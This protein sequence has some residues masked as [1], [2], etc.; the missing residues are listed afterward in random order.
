[1]NDLDLI[2]ALRAD[3]AGPDPDQLARA[4]H[5]LLARTAATPRERRRRGRGRRLRWV[6]LTAALAV[7]LVIAVLEVPHAAS[8]PRKAL[9]SPAHLNNA[10][11]WLRAAAIHADADSASRPSPEQWIYSEAVEQQVGSPVSRDENWIQFDGVKSA[12]WQSGQLIVH[13]G[14]PQPGNEGSAMAAYEATATPMTS[15]DAL[16]SLPSDPQALL[17]VVDAQVAADPGSVAPAGASPQP[18]STRAQLEFDFLSQLLWQAAQ[19]APASAEATVFQAMA[20][21][22]GV[23]A[24]AGVT[25]A[26]GRPAIALSDAGDEQ[27]LLFDPQ[28]YQVIGLRT[29]SD[30]T[31]PANPAATKFATGKTLPE[32]T[33]VDSL[34]LA[35]VAFV[36][37]PGQS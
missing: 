20:T 27:Q 30:G 18:N 28:T 22:P 23:T 31:W 35:R 8:P 7:T 11:Q 2:R 37:Q 32:G 10:V 19:A 21:I 26:A 6:P 3:V 34:A 15:Y 16:T 4:R 24:Q 13:S 5:R 29:V 36:A 33:V 25:D 17:S 14:P 1:M 9:G 12:Y